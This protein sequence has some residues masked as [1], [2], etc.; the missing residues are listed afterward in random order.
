[1]GFLF[2]Y[3]FGAKINI[4]MVCT[5]NICRSPIAHAVLREMLD[6]KGLTGRVR[7]ESAGTH[8][9]IRGLLPDKRSIIVLK[10]NGVSIKKLKT[11]PF[12]PKDANDFDYILVMD[13]K[14]L[15]TIQQRMGVET[16]NINLLLEHGLDVPDPYYAHPDEF[17]YVFSL[18]E[19]A[20]KVFLDK[21]IIEHNLEA[22]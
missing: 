10:E 4:L 14:N 3:L 22:H 9:P 2:K 11:R 12:L 21:L 1:M 13:N 16:T 17:R 8:V 5:A 15:E 6:A 19:G 18:I 20:C 7:V